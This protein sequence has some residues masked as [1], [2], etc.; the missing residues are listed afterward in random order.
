MTGGSAR[1][2][3]AGPPLPRPPARAARAC[4]RAGVRGP[5]GGRHEGQ[6][7]AGGAVPHLPALPRRA[8][9]AVCASTGGEA[10]GRGLTGRGGAQYDAGEP[11]SVCGHR[12]AAGGEAG[13]KAS[14]FPS[15]V[16][17]GFLYLGSYDH[18]S[19]AELLKTL[20]ISH[21]LNVRPEGPAPPEQL[22]RCAGLALRLAYFDWLTS[23]GQLAVSN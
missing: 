18:A 6:A 17:P 20:G 2:C 21:I 11:C 5:G 22:A 16:V 3:R 19:R 1:H 8:P 4:V 10:R 14:A 12:L 9:P 15:E 23:D 13:E 7:R